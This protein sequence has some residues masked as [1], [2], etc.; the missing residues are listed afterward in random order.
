MIA[1]IE[2]NPGY[3]ICALKTSIILLALENDLIY[4]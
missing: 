4:N 1:G 2:N 3:L